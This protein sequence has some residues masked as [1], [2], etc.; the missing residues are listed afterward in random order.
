MRLLITLVLAANAFA[1]ENPAARWWSHSLFL[2]DDKLEGR[3]T[4]SEGHRKA[5][6][7]VAGEFEK[8]GLKPAGGAAYVQPV[9]LTTSKILESE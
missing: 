3:N 1:A 2:A 8:L 5:A 4:G 9:K 7:Y 6:Q